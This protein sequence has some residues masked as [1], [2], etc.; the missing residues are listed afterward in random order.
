MISHSKGA[1]ADRT[2]L[3][4]VVPPS[5]QKGDVV[6]SVVAAFQELFEPLL[7][8]I[9]FQQTQQFGAARFHLL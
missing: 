8:E 7:D 9:R 4:V 3:F 6:P 5:L 1:G 2:L